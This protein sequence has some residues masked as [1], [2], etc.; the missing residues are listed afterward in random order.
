MADKLTP[1]QEQAV[2]NRG[3]K[4]LVSAA[5]G[6]GKTKVL[7]DRLLSYLTDPG[8]C[9]NLDDFLIIT[10]TKAAASEL[11]S[12]IAARLSERISLEPENVHLQKQMQRLYLTKISTIHGL[13]AELLREYAYR[14][15][16]PLDFRIADET[17]CIEIRESVLRQMLT[18]VYER[19]ICSEDVFALI[20][21]QG[22]GRD[23][24]KIPE[25]ITRVY[26]SARCHLNPNE[27]LEE[28]QSQTCIDLDEDISETPWGRY[29][30][31]NLQ[32]YLDSQI[33]V[34][35]ACADSLEKCEGMEKAAAYFRELQSQLISLRRANTWDDIQRAKKIDYGR[36]TFPKKNPDPVLTQRV[37][38]ARDACK[39]GVAKRTKCFSDDAA[40]VKADLLACSS[41]VRGLIELVR[42]FDREYSEAKRSRRIM[43]FSDLE[44]KTLDLLLGKQRSGPTAAAIEI[45]KRFREVM[46]DEYQDSNGV[47][48]AI[49]SALTDTRKNCFLVGDVKQSIY[50]FRLADPGI[51]LEKYNCYTCCDNA[52]SGEGRKVLLSHNFR[53]GPEVIEAVNAVF[54]TCMSPQIGGLQYGE[55]EELREGIPHNP[56]PEPGV[57]LHVIKT[58]EDAYAE[59]ADYVASQIRKL[60]QEKKMIRQGDQY[61]PV[62]PEDIV[63][64]LRSPGSAASYFQ[65]SLEIAGIRCVSGNGQNLLDAPEIDTFRSLLMA[66][67]NPRQDIP[68][69]SVLA[70]PIFGFTADDLARIRSRMI[71]GSF[72]DALVSDNDPRTEQFKCILASLRQ[73]SRMNTLTGLLEKCITLTDMDCVYAAMSDGEVKNANIQSFFQL[74]A[75]YENGGLR[76]LIQF[77]DYL[78]SLERK[79]FP[80]ASASGQNA[81]RVMSIHKS[82]GLEFPVVFLCNLSRKFNLENLN[83]QILCDRDMGIG[84][85]VV[86]QTR[87][88]RYSSISKRAIAAK[89][90]SESV[91]E[92]MRILYVAMT[93]A[94]DRLVMTYASKGAESDLKQIAARKDF[95]GGKLV[96]LE[97][98]CPGDWV[99]LTALGRTEAGALQAICEC[100]V[101]ASISEYPWK[102]CFQESSNEPVEVCSEEEHATGMPEGAMEYLRRA[103]SFH[104]PYEAATMAPSKRTATDRKGRVKDEE[105]Y[106]DAPDP[107]Y[108]HR[109]WRKPAFR[110]G[111]KN[112]TAYGS[113]VHLALQY[114][115]YEN[116]DS[117]C[118]VEQEIE[119]LKKEGFLTGEQAEMVDCKKLFRF[120]STEIGKKLVRGIPC[121]R[122]FKFSILD[123]GKKYD[124]NLNGEK[125]LLQGVI[126]CALI[127]DSGLTVIDFKTD[128]VTEETLNAV[129]CRY[130]PQVEVYAE[131]LSRIYEKPVKEKLLYFFHIGRFEPV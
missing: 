108:M 124:E 2:I 97:A 73:E 93:R 64:L 98:S 70:S 52:E 26:D 11:R 51:F 23:D 104:Y 102:I 129:A 120:F 79:G 37:K 92:E 46:V 24:S 13:C 112:A 131:A 119:R 126:D 75:E 76:D 53:S 48:D 44:Q 109:V 3:G 101:S 17:E 31:C 27:W 20:D 82:K 41:G 130:R 68:L 33:S 118:S 107:R 95:D 90:E 61:R 29:L 28:C 30:I 47:Q 45:S 83:G 99:L 25:L 67:Q 123:D 12:K 113:T 15:D 116:C 62:E 85:A 57:E 50:Q 9:T 77:L 114:I 8:E 105:A 117:L 34:M 14:L 100:P 35:A 40:Q 5:A 36:L 74:A 84:L 78:D 103:L 89:M 59:E 21:T 66:I 38:A 81:V 43:D 19:D 127:E 86:D 121:L 56:L 58:H 71:K 49:F 111:R 60:L 69:I 94:R 106:N 87:R 32:V 80:A 110:N 4:L 16:V 39:Q 22:L 65:H 96:C 88:V 125:V 10:Y 6:S 122:E 91:S 63:I 1:Q 54:R 55:E 128:H 42:W 18:E 115:Q 7:V 72:Y